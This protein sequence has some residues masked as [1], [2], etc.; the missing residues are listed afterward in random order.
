[1]RTWSPRPL[2]RLGRAPFANGTT[3]V[4]LSIL[5]IGTTMGTWSAIAPSFASFRSFFSTTP[6]EQE[7]ARTTIYLA[8]GASLLMNAG[9]YLVFRRTTPAIV[10]A[11]ATL[12][13]FGLS[14]YAIHAA[15][16][17]QSTMQAKRAE[18]LQQQRTTP[19]SLPEEATA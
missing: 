1:M 13:L 8:G 19:Q 5:S 16:P 12:G 3:D 7:T 14:W 6:Q 10:G 15:P 11:I 17:V 2:H 4:G 9:I 18:Q